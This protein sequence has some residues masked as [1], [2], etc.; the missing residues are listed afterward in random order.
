MGNRIRLGGLAAL[1]LAALLGGCSNTDPI[2]GEDNTV[3]FPSIRVDWQ[4]QPLE[5]PGVGDGDLTAPTTEIGPQVRRPHGYSMAMEY[6]GGFGYGES[7]QVLGPSDKVRLDDAR[8][9]GGGRLKH[10]YF[11]HQNSA[12][13]RVGG[14]MGG[15]V[16]VEGIIGIG[17]NTVSMRIKR[18]RASESDT[19]SGLGPVL[20]GRITVRPHWRFRIYGQITRTSFITE[21]S[22]GS[23]FGYEIGGRFDAIPGLGV[24][25]GWRLW[26]YW[27]NREHESDYFLELS[28]PILGLAVTF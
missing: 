9:V 7:S 5:E 8:V 11:V 12:L 27:A 25:G 13:F 24:F 2:E 18:G 23:M 14:W 26:N 1:V 3:L 10:E 20:G 21:E 4:L 28:G 17:I 16:A 22:Y 19:D 15:L 6:E